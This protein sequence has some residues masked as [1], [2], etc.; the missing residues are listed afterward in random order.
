MR[1]NSLVMPSLLSAPYT[2]LERSIRELEEAG[3]RLFHYDV[4]D[5][6]F[7]PNLSGGPNIIKSLEAVIHSR[8]DVHLMVSNPGRVIPWFDFPAVRS[9]TIH[10]ET[11]EDLFRN[12]AEIRLRGKRVGVAINPA[13][14]AAA[15]DPVLGAVDQ[16]LVMTVHPGQ[17]GQ[18]LI[19]DTLAKARAL[20]RR[21]DE[22]GY[23]YTIQADG[24]IREENIHVVHA[25]GAEELVA[26]AAI[27]ENPG[28]AGA[29]RRL[30]RIVQGRS[31]SR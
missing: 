20:A 19:V 29:Y 4:M 30:E 17:G 21:R 5:G 16:I 28:P 10:I 11:E 26:G 15:L 2:H 14:P 8:F 25:A 27:F 9:I 7:V 24:G 23:R 18:E 31:V 3:A 13:T 1:P 22:R 6:H 12:F